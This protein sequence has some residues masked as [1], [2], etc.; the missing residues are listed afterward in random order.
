MIATEKVPAPLFHES[1]AIRAGEFVFLSGQL[2]ADQD[3]LSPARGATALPLC[4][5]LGRAADA[6][7]HGKRAGHLPRGRNR[8]AARTA[9][10]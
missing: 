7:D 1:Q 5:Q 8:S 4:D 9:A 2:A 3:G 10:F 6:P